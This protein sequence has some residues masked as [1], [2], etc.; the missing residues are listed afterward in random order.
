[1]DVT[2]Y[3]QVGS[4]IKVR[5]AWGE[6]CQGKDISRRLETEEGKLEVDVDLRELALSNWQQLLLISFVFL[7]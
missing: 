3:C 1:M 4:S 7:L 6:F 2:D 5:Y